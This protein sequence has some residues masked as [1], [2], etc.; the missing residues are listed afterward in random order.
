MDLFQVFKKSVAMQLRDKGF[1]IV[2]AMTN[3]KNPNY[4]VYLFEDTKELREE[5]EIIQ[6]KYKER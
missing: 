1:Q 3:K 2:D 6:G 4:V 5:F